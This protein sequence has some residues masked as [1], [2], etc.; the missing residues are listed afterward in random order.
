MAVT[1]FDN[2]GIRRHHCCETPARAFALSLRQLMKVRCTSWWITGKPE[3]NQLLLSGVGVEKV[4]F[5]QNDGKL[6]D[7]KCL[8]KPRTSFVG[9]PNAKFF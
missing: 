8:G 6:G 3:V 7:R 9:H 5:S 1:L 4:P 2:T